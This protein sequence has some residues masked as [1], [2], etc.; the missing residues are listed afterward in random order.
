ML[1]YHIQCGRPGILSADSTLAF[2]FQRNK[3]RYAVASHTEL[4]KETEVLQSGPCSYTKQKHDTVN[5]RIT[6]TL[7]RVRVTTVPAETQ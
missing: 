5:V 1:L 7:W 6:S 3:R 4:G 2:Q